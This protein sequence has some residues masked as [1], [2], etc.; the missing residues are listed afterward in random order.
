[1]SMPGMDGIS[2]FKT[3]KESNP[4]LADR[5]IFISGDVLHRDW[6]RIKSSIGRPIIEKPFDPQQVRDAAL[7]LLTPGGK[8]ND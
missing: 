2:F 1:V 6:D 5:L 7:R 3:L 4:V 8:I